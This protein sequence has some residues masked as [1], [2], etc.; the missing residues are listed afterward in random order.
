[1][2]ELFYLWVNLRKQYG[3]TVMLCCGCS[4]LWQIPPPSVQYKKKE[5]NYFADGRIWCF[6]RL[7]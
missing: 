2:F 4:Q 5:K 3:A 1:M 7:T 6:D